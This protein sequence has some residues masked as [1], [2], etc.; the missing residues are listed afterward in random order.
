MT[1]GLTADVVDEISRTKHDPDWMHD[2]RLHCLKIYQKMPLPA[3]GPPLDKL[4]LDDIT[5]YIPR[6]GRPATNWE[7]VPADVRETFSKLG[8]PQAEEKFLAGVGAQVDSEMVYHRLQD[9]VKA[10]GVIYED[11]DTA[12]HG[13]HAELIRQHFMTLIKPT[14]HKFAALH[15]AVWSGGSFVYVPPGVAITIP[16]QA[17]FRLNAKGAGQ[18]EHTLIIVDEK[19][20]LHFIEGCSAPRYNAIS[21]H[22]GAVELFVRAGATLRYTTIENWSRNMYNLNTKR[23][24][25]AANATIEWVSGSFGSCT[26]CLYPQSIL[27]GEKAKSSYSGVT[28]AGPDQKLDTGVQVIHAAPKTSSTTIA[29]SL[30]KGGGECTFRSHLQ[31][32]AKATDS[33]ASLACHSLL[34]DTH[35]RT[36]TIPVLDIRTAASD[37]GQEA[38][39]GRISDELIL[40]LRTRG[41]S[42]DQAQKF[43]VNGFTDNFTRELPLE[44]ALEMNNLLDLELKRQNIPKVNL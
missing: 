11:L 23:A 14:D 39:V 40:Y 27:A 30:A 5:T 6:A 43:V 28:F 18:F 34:L 22:A 2:F 19:A 38:T 44:Y 31:I 3:W 41:F 25:V 13:P 12:L 33:R 1:T 17:Y 8:I 9:L 21:L 36:D 42:N 37:V 7:D 26:T 10:D 15:G 35:S 20:S 29:K 24:H 4:N 32:N 16:L